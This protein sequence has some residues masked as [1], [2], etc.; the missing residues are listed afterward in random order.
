MIAVL[1]NEDWLQGSPTAGYK[2]ALP[3][4]LPVMTSSVS[5]D[6]PLSIEGEGRGEGE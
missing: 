1:E 4:V 6:C 2:L 5:A 3:G